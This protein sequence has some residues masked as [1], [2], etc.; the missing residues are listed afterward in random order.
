MADTKSREEYEEEIGGYG[1]SYGS[2]DQ[3]VQRIQQAKANA[4]ARSQQQIQPLVQTPVLDASKAAAAERAKRREEKRQAAGVALPSSATP[5]VTPVTMNPEAD[6][7]GLRAMPTGTVKQVGSG[8]A[9]W[10]NISDDERARIIAEYNDDQIIQ[11]AE[12]VNKQYDEKMAAYNQ[13]NAAYD[14][15][16]KKNQSDEVINAMSA[17]YDAPEWV[18]FRA[19]GERLFAEAKKYDDEADALRL[20]ADGLHDQAL[21][22]QDMRRLNELLPKMDEETRKALDAYAEGNYG[23]GLNTNSKQYYELMAKLGVSER[24]AS[25]LAETWKRHKN[26]EGMEAFEEGVAKYTK[27]IPGVTHAVA[28]LQSISAN[29]VAPFTGFL[30][31]SFAGLSG[32]RYRSADP[33]GALFAPTAFADTVRQTTASDIAGENGNIIRQGVADIYNG[34]MGAADNVL[35]TMMYGEKGTIVMAMDV[36]Q[37]TVRNASASGATKEQ[38]LALGLA[39]AGLEYMTEQVAVENMLDILNGAAKE[40]TKDAA[41]KAA[42]NGFINFLKQ[43]GKNYVEELPQELI[44]FWGNAAAEAVILRQNSDFNR[45]VRNYMEE[46]GMTQEEAEAA[47]WKDL[48]WDGSLRVAWDT[49]WST[50]FQTGFATGVQKVMENMAKDS[51]EGAPP[52][53]T[54]PVTQQKATEAVQGEKTAQEA[55]TPTAEQTAQQVMQGLPGQTAQQTVP[56][57]AGIKTGVAAIDAAVE[58]ARENGTVTNSQATAIL[59]TEGA[60]D[61]LSKLVEVTLPGTKAGDRAA[62]KGAVM[63]IAEAPEAPVASESIRPPQ[64]QVETQTAEQEQAEPQQQTQELSNA[65]QGALELAKLAEVENYPGREQKPN[66]NHVGEIYVGKDWLTGEDV[67]IERTPADDMKD[68]I[69]RTRKD[70]L[71]KVDSTVNAKPAYFAVTWAVDDGKITPAQGAK[72]FI[73][74]YDG[75]KDALFDLKDEFGRLRERAIEKAKKYPEQLA[76]ERGMEQKAEQDAPTSAGEAAPSVLDNMRDGENGWGEVYSTA[77]EALNDAIQHTSTELWDAYVAEFD[78]A[79][80]KGPLP[81]GSMPITDAVNAVVQDVRQETITPMQGAQLL[82]EV[83]NDGGADALRRI[84]NPHTGNLHNRN[85]EKAKRYGNESQVAETDSHGG[86]GQNTVGGAQSQ[87]EHEVKT[88]AQETNTYAKTKDEDLQKLSEKAKEK[89]P[90]IYQYDATTEKESLHNAELRTA[91]EEDRAAEYDALMEKDGW[92]AEDNDTAYAIEK[93]L[94]RDGKADEATKLERRRR[95]EVTNAAQ[96]VQSQAKYS[97]NADEAYSNGAMA[98]G[99]LTKDNVPKRFWKKQGFDT[100]KAELTKSF[101]EM[102]EKIS[103]IS[104]GDTEAM[105]DV[106]RSLARF[107]NTTAWFGM[108]KGLTKAAEAGLRNLDYDMAKTVALT[109]VTN[110]PGDFVKRSV[111]E[112]VKTVRFQS[113]LASLKSPVRN[114]IGNSAMVIDA[115]SDSTVGRFFDHLVSYA[116][117]KR[118]VGND[119]GRTKEFVEGGKKAAE[120]GSLCVELAIP[121]ESDD[122]YM[123]QQGKKSGTAHSRTFSPRGNALARFLSAVE[124]YYSYAYGVSDLFFEGGHASAVDA[125]LEKLGD[126]SGLTAEE[127]RA[128]ARQVGERRTF[129]QDGTLAEATRKAKQAAN[130]LTDKISPDMGFGDLLLPFSRVNANMAQVAADY[131]GLGV[132]GAVEIFTLIRDAKKGKDID[133]GRQRKAVTDA[134]RGV[135]GA[136]LV[137]MMTAFA[138]SGVLKGADDDDWDRAAYEESTGQIGAQFNISAAIRGLTGESTEW[139]KDDVVMS[140]DFLE[141]YN[142]Q[143]LLGTVLAED[144]KNG[145]DI[146]NYPMHAFN[147]VLEAVLNNPSM[148]LVNELSDLVQDLGKAETAEDYAG[149]GGEF[150]GEIASGFIPNFVRQIAKTIDQVKRDTTAKTSLETAVNKILTGIPFAS[151][152]LPAKYGADGEPIARNEPGWLTAVNNFLNPA[153][154]SQL[155]DPAIADYLGALSDRTG[156]ASIYPESKAPRSFKVDGKEVEVYGKEDRETY[157][158]TYM[159]NIETVYGGLINDGEFTELSDGRQLAVLGYAKEYAAAMAKKAL[160]PDYEMPAWMDGM[161]DD[162]VNTVLLHEYKSNQNDQGN[163]FSE[164]KHGEMVGAGIPDG[165]AKGVQSAVAGLKPQEGYSSVRTVQQLEAIMDV[166]GL[167][168]A[169][170]TAALKAYMTDEQDAKLDAFI[171]LGKGKRAPLSNDQFVATYVAWTEQSKEDKRT[172]D[173]KRRD[174]AKALGGGYSKDSDLVKAIYNL[175]QGVKSK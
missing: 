99:E 134:A 19:E 172:A 11:Q 15:W 50:L 138:L 109:Q 108:S 164:N 104:E 76:D 166:S 174:I 5:T 116:T 18:A 24:E 21:Y 96:V 143:M 121:M 159:E 139:Q 68:I 29:V 44:S 95:E 131:T 136:G 87:F 14:E 100:W 10:N 107:R 157:H 22:I 9:Y 153:T 85:L 162:P 25:R 112:V 133:P 43:S 36:Y 145:E 71:D 77:S 34:A 115:V 86:F 53:T 97:R 127:R 47:A 62:V 111:G 2:R 28:N 123:E 67:F 148:E 168:D 149:I 46:Q 125:S 48:L 1:K 70:V 27:A 61:A 49:G 124:K 106:I 119:I 7:S 32:G 144:I 137:A 75:G 171:D 173:E 98:L 132:K 20:Q 54:P 16:L 92:T 155:K 128:V 52:T 161:E 165:K 81:R 38:A 60:M 156:N 63:Q 88:S 33:N 35:R 93:Q 105:K 3:Y 23:Y 13:A 84:Y 90:T 45:N 4:E 167:T 141:P 17:D 122:K 169:Q 158:R 39:S 103:A 110:I 59:Q 140:L 69:R 175:Y 51:A 58:Y 66:Q 57:A 12:A 94:M 163:S 170:Q 129:K 102:V 73:D 83:F 74:T 151:E 26:K 42:K 142:A 160:Y 37:R 146:K 82:S 135:T 30:A 80:D 6:T 8:N 91:T 65:E 154:V 147:S 130:K 101:S 31:A 113:M 89:D 120:F 118:E 114:V 79:V 56:Q 64:T 41:E 117:G 40:A 150:V 78:D 152:A 72:L 126:S 55:Q